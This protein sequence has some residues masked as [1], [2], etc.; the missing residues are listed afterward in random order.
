M[1]VGF[2]FL[3][4]EKKK[5]KKTK[6]RD[7]IKNLGLFLTRIRDDCDVL[8]VASI[9]MKYTTQPYK[10]G[11]IDVFT[12]LILFNFFRNPTNKPY[13]YYIIVTTI[14]HLRVYQS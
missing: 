6:T 9:G 4:F 2:K 14:T 1:A 12:T 10:G 7:L 3:S 11:F 5:K 13:P 8:F